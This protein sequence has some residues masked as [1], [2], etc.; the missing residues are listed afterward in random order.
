MAKRNVTKKP[1]SEQE[2]TTN[3][4]LAVFST[5]LLGVLVLMVLQRLLEHANTWRAGMLMACIL[6]GAAV[7]GAIYGV[8]MLYQEHTGKRSAVRRILCGHTVLLLCLATIGSMAVIRL[9]GAQPIK[10]LYVLLPALAVYYLIYHTYAPEFFLIAADAGAALGLMWGV[11]RA[12]ISNELVWVAYAAVIAIVLL[13]VVQLACVWSIR[14]HKGKCSFRGRQID[15]HFSRNAY[16]MLTITPLLMAVLVA[17]VLFAPTSL[18]IF[19]GIAAAYLFI[20]AVYYTVKL[21]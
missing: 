20:T 5:C 10:A 11:H 9:L 12:L 2:Y 6:Q 3:K 21:M 18:L 14:S 16:T 19:M 4:V 15:T 8:W 7:A 13:A 17:L 1:I